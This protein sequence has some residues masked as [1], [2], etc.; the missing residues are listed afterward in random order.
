MPEEINFENE[1]I[2]LLD[3]EPFVPFFISLTSGERYEVGNPRSVAIGGS[4]VAIL[5]EKTGLVFFR[6][7]KIVAVDAPEPAV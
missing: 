2:R 7:N 3:R 6:K 5:G 1:L 4:V